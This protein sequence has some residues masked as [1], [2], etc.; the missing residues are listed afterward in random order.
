MTDGW[1][2]TA[3]SLATVAAGGLGGALFDLLH[4][5]VPWLSGSM[6]TIGAL[7]MTGV[8]VALTPLMRDIG[9]LFAGASLGSTVTPEA[10]QT[11]A[12][13][14]YSLIGL[15]LSAALTVAAAKTILERVYGWDRATAY[16]AAVP[17]A[18]SMVMALA[19][20]STG[21][22]R[23]IAMV[24]AIRL[25]ALVAVLPLAITSTMPTHAPA[26][27]AVIDA[28]GMAVVFAASLTLASVMRRL[29][30]ANPLFMGGMVA[31][32][33]LHV[34]DTLSGDLP[35][36][37]TVA[38]LVLIG[39]FAGIRFKGATPRHLLETLAPGLVSLSVALAMSLG[40]GY[41][42]YR[43]TGLRLAEVLVAFAP[44]GLEA[45]VMVGA[46]LGLDMLYI[47][48]HHVLRAVGLNM[49]A[50]LFAPPRADAGRD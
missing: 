6:L 27:H 9:L 23:R 48:T 49:V 37:L 3:R 18:L 11:I 38:G 7:T 42:V 15:A 28:G 33:L 35:P 50:P 19:A 24:Q 30:F 47:S 45:M 41:L 26:A 16:L 25:F 8:P 4:M 14:P 46:S 43:A 13:Y 40:I 44:G 32:T 29:K 39:I 17:G 1:S 5:P 34:S 22:V 12:R 36:P 10:L 31:S 21:D 2:A 20:E